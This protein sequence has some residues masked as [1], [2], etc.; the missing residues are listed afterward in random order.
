[1]VF[2]NNSFYKKLFCSIFILCLHS[3]I[4]VKDDGQL[5]C[6]VHPLLWLLLKLKNS[7]HKVYGACKDNPCERQADKVCNFS[8]IGIY[9]VCFLFAVTFVLND[10]FLF[11]LIASVH[12]FAVN[13]SLKVMSGRFYYFV[14]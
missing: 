14:F 4:L 5:L 13:N 11:I 3:A 12:N 7:C 1:M 8:N 10:C 6:R 9:I 2:C